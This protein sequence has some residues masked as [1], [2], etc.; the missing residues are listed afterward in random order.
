MAQ[1]EEI[2]MAE[3]MNLLEAEPA[4]SSQPGPD[5]PALCEQFVILVS[6]GKCKEAIGTQLTQ[7]GVKRL[8]AKDVEKY[9]KRYMT[10]V[11]AK[12]AETFVD[13]FISLYSRVVG[14]FVPIIDVEALQS[15]LK[16]DYVI[17]KELFTR[18]WK[19]RAAVWTAA[20]GGEHGAYHNE[21][22][23]KRS[24]LTWPQMLQ[25]D[26]GREFMGS[27]TQEMEKHKTY[28]RRGR[29]ETHRDQ[30]IV[31]VAV[32]RCSLALLSF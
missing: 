17:N 21:M 16:K 20:H 24:T 5:I 22:I 29:A 2:M 23:Y 30:A 1:S 13:S 7:E 31:A 25:V 26:P 4:D 12:T 10:Y 18:C 9:Y 11:G 8:D 15:D 27:V 19:P 14:I 6:T 32:R 28:I 3:V